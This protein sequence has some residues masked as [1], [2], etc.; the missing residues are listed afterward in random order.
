MYA[1]ELNKISVYEN[2]PVGNIWK[3]TSKSRN[4]LLYD[5]TLYQY[6]SA[7][8]RKHSDSNKIKHLRSWWG[9]LEHGQKLQ[10]HTHTYSLQQRTVSGV[11]YEQGDPC[12]L[13]IKNVGCCEPITYATGK[14][15]VL[16][17]SANAEHST[18]VYSGNTLRRCVGFDFAIEDQRSC[19]CVP[20]QICIRCVHYKFD[21]L[22]L[23]ILAH[24]P[25][26][27][28]RYLRQN[29]NELLT[30]GL[31][32]DKPISLNIDKNKYFMA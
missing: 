27:K 25:A 22:G 21:K 19:F 5:E 13:F 26:E 17:F 14:G 15:K 16:L 9:L 2:A 24:S 4:P 3:R 12:C 10:P 31:F 6:I 8:V 30:A 18:E 23:Q 29:M 32:K 28:E 7:L 11:V 1:A 20:D